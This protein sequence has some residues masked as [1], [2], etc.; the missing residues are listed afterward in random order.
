MFDFS[1]LEILFKV[2]LWALAISV[3]FAIW[4]IVE[5]AIYLFQHL[6]LV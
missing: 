1:G 6:R 2:M 3:P 4:K 5:V